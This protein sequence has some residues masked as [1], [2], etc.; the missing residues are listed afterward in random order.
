MLRINHWALLLLPGS[1]VLG[2]VFVLP[3]LGLAASS[4]HLHAGPGRVHPEF[5]LLNYWNFVTDPFYLEI[6][7]YS[8]QLGA[9]VVGVCVLL[10]YPVA[11][12][13]ARTHTRYRGF[14]LF[15]V[16]APL[17]VSVVIR[18]LGW[19]PVLSDNGLI[20]WILMGVGFIREPLRLVNNFTGVVI[21]LVHA[22]LP[23]MI[24]SLMAV[25]QGIEPEIEEASINLGA[26]PIETF[27]R[28]VLPLSRPGLLAGS[29]L[30]FTMAVSAYTTPAVMGGK[31]VLV[32]ATFIEQQIRALLN[33]AFGATA[34]VILM[35][36][37]ASL[38]IIAVR[39]SGREV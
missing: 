32:M 26:G 38:T 18:N 14:F 25:I 7:L 8:F 12:F 16:I 23:F 3:I 10:G 9:V 27:C 4:L 28:V 5:T 17:L 30:V 15:F 39:V 35:I 20:N 36:V 19:I 31:R 34:A 37:V 21:G 11:Y 29:L 6:L 22:L 1:L 2:V 13:L 24:L 33:Y